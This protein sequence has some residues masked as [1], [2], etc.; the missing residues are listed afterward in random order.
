MYMKQLKVL[1]KNKQVRNIAMTGD[2]GIG[3]STLIRNYERKYPKLFSRK[4]FVYLSVTNLKNDSNNPNLQSEL[5]ERLL[6]K[7][8]K[9]EQWAG[10]FF[11]HT[12]LQIMKKS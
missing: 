3:K 12:I 10:R 2:V 4:K 9:K 1:M 6:K 11:L 8:T 5:E 7:M